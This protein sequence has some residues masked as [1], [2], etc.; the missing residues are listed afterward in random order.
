MRSN[1]FNS[2]VIQGHLYKLCHILKIGI[3]I[4]FTWWR[5]PEYPEKTTNLPQ[6][7]DKFHHIMLYWLHLAWAGF[8]L[9]TLVVIGTDDCIG[10]YKSNYHTITTTTANFKH[11]SVCFMSPDLDLFWHIL[12]ST[13]C[14]GLKWFV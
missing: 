10:I 12:R 4:F 7:T 8:K 13:I 2:K 11:M 9:T 1:I 14:P 3:K 6:V 5:K